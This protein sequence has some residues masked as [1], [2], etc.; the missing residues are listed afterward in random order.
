[1]EQSSSEAVAFRGI[2]FEGTIRESSGCLEIDIFE[3]KRGGVYD[4]RITD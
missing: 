4:L 1:M 2:N 3:L